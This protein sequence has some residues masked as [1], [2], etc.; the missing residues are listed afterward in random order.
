GLLATAAVVL[1]AIAALIVEMRQRPFA[2]TPT[3]GAAIAIVDF[4]NLGKR[5]NEEWIRAALEEELATELAVGGALR[6]VPGEIVRPAH[7]DLALPG[8]GGYAQPSL[9]AL[10][11]RLGTDFVLSGSYLILD[12][13]DGS[14]GPVRLDLSLQDARSGQTVTFS[15]D[16]ALATLP[17]LVKKAGA[18]L[19]RTLALETGDSALERIARAQPATLDLARHMGLA[20]EALHRSDPA[21][22]RD[23]LLDAVVLDPQY[24]PA[25]ALLAQVWRDLGYNAKALAAAQ[26]AAAASGG[27]PIEQQRQI[28]REVAVQSAQWQRVVDLD[29]QALALHPDDL[30]MHLHLSEDLASAG[31]QDEASKAL[32]RARELP[33]AADEPR[34]EILAAHIADESGNYAEQ[35]AHSEAAL[36]LAQARG[37]PGMIARARHSL[38]SALSALGRIDE[39]QRYANEAIEDYRRV[40]DANGEAAMHDLLA[41][42]W[43]QRVRPQ[44]EQEEYQKAL[45]IYQRI[46]NQSGVA[47]VYRNIYGLL[48][49]HGDRDGAQR[50][51]DNALAILRET[52]DHKGE[53]A[54]MTQLAYLQLY[55][56]LDEAVRTLARMVELS[57]TTGDRAQQIDIVTRY[58]DALRKR[59]ELGQ[60]Q[61]QCE[62]ARAGSD[63]S[64]NPFGLIQVDYVCAMVALDTGRAAEGTA[65]LERMVDS[66]RTLKEP[67]YAEL[68]DVTLATLE[69]QR[70]KWES[71]ATRL[72]SAA[73]VYAASEDVSDEARV[74]ALLAL[75]RHAQGRGPERDAAVL[76]ART[77]RA[78]VTND[79]DLFSI[80]AALYEI[81]ARTG[82]DN[83]AV[84]KLLALADDAERRHALAEAL[85][86]RLAAFQLLQ[87]AHD[88]Q[89]E[90]VRRQIETVARAQGFASIL[91]RLSEPAG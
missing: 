39:S 53:I 83:Q 26:R 66:A 50:A 9:D 89:A 70:R 61:A 27:L 3:H 88:P 68:G 28:E 43:R 24:A 4:N 84:G 20:L 69:M 64:A 13:A 36:K 63:G 46:G 5:E 16:G 2:L 85:E 30:E 65:L 78:R 42:T 90:R 77:L 31:L 57:R 62:S 72:E 41:V 19:R 25:N 80:N 10:R 45:A 59:G 87:R 58:S 33:A 91:A 79:G 38:A 67:A 23:E 37:A 22:A 40:D 29:R 44:A 49:N 11:R 14:R 34:V 18:R 6:I 86:T 7:A 75:C 48:L 54:V 15:E 35:A 60:A 17:D 81:D 1:I 55:E 82:A 73:A 21:R 56:S 76:R 8:V 12:A 51:M 32:A 71:A 74:Q 52:G 47:T